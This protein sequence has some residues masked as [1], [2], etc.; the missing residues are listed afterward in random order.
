MEI[1][2]EGSMGDV[3][4]FIVW[5]GFIGFAPVLFYFEGP[6]NEGD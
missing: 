6:V 4:A 1:H 5:S 2:S 3:L